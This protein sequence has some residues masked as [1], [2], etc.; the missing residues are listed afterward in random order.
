MV[1]TFLLINQMFHREK[2]PNSIM[3][4]Q[5]AQKWYHIDKT[6]HKTKQVMCVFPTHTEAGAE[7][8][9]NRIQADSPDTRTKIWEHGRD[10]QTDSGEDM[11]L[12]HTV[13]TLYPR[14]LTGW[15]QDSPL[16]TLLYWPGGGGRDTG[17]LWKR[18]GR[19]HWLPA[20]TLQVSEGAD[21]RTRGRGSGAG[22]GLPADAAGE[23]GGH[24]G[25]RCWAGSSGTDRQRSSLLA[26]TFVLCVNLYE[27]M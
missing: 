19:P 18:L 26:G 4:L 12:L 15:M 11:W 8:S 22:G 5:H 1:N 10:S 9:T 20:E 7:E 16:L 21:R 3:H 14:V 23:D 17:L 13:C 6:A 25:E 24:E 27:I 2:W